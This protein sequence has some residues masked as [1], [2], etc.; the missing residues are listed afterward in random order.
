LTWQAANIFGDQQ[1]PDVRGMCLKD[2]LF[3][4]E[5]RGLKVVIQGNP[6]GQVKTQSIMPGTKISSYPAI[7]LELS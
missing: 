1:V 6:G 2:A 7:T 5:N 4:L 3:L